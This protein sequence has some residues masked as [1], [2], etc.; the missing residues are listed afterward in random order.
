MIIEH[1][2][3]WT[4]QLEQLKEYYTKYFRGSP[5]LKYVNQAKQFESYFIS[6]ES[7]ARLEIMSK[8]EIPENANDPVNHQ[9]LGIIH[10]AFGVES[11]QN[12]DEKA[13]ELTR[14]GFKIL[15]GPRR[16]GD[17]Y[18]EFETL[19]PDNNRVEVTTKFVDR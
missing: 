15:S 10:L 7:G 6:F 9:Y 4:R 13:S 2:A 11:M 1:V 3:I 17:G 16:T 14:D 19:D 12:V 8:P 18:Y 5:N